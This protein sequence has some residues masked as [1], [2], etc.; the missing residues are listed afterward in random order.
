[1][2][3]NRIVPPL[4]PWRINRGMPSRALVSFRSTRDYNSRLRAGRSWTWSSYFSLISLLC[5]LHVFALDYVI[6][7][8]FS[9]LVCVNCNVELIKLV[10][11]L[12]FISSSIVM[13]AFSSP[14]RLLGIN[15][16]VSKIG[17]IHVSIWIVVLWLLCLSS[18]L[19]VY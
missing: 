13:I 6:L 9:L 18:N 14:F 12:R 2:L 1:M 4:N 10:K 11:T 15:K 3:F 19:R 5:L 7:H 17:H 8:I 16:L